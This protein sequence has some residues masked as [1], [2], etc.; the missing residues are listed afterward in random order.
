MLGT[1][2]KVF[3]IALTLM[4]IFTILV[5]YAGLG[6]GIVL[7][8]CND[9]VV[10]FTEE[11]IIPKG[12]NQFEIHYLARMWTFEPAELILP[13]NAEVDMYFS[14]VDVQHGFIVPGTNLNLMVIP[15]TVNFAH[16][17][18]DTKGEYMVI[19]HEYC[20]L[21]HHNMMGKIK[22]L[23]PEEYTRKMQELTSSLVSVGQDLVEDRQCSSCHTS[24]GTEGLGPTFKGLYG[25]SR[26]LADGTQISVD[27]KYLIDSIRNP[28][29]QIVK[30]YDPGSMPPPETPLTDQEI[31]EIISYIKSLK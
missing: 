13:Q 27:E 14:A 12:N 24:D 22:V 1:E 3:Y 25:S 9:R 2:R 23:A 4:L 30:G 16:H 11:K 17:R 26:T 29:K 6:L 7:P 8:T 19:C 21:N 20:G 18:F 28:D 10:P 5:V 31:D 15:G